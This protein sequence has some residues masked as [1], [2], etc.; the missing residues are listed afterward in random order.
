MNRRQNS[1]KRLVKDIDMNI[2]TTK[3]QEFVRH[4]FTPRGVRTKYC[5][6]P[7]I[8]EDTELNVEHIPL[9]LHQEL[10]KNEYKETMCLF[11][12]IHDLTKRS[13]KHIDFQQRCFLLQLY[14]GQIELLQ[15]QY[16][17]KRYRLITGT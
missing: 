8:Y 13:N 14:N 2:Y 9:I 1:F 7:T 17:N 11:D 5:V 6:L 12:K 15:Y 3:D 4:Y 16:R 10:L